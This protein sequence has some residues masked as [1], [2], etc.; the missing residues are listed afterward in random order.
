MLFLGLLASTAVNPVVQDEGLLLG[1]GATQ[2]GRQ[3]LALVAA[4]AFSFT[5]SW[6]L[7]KGVDR[8]LP[9]RVTEDEEQS[10]LDRAMHAET[11]YDFGS[12]RTLGRR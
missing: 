10:G 12:V 11:A 7:A 6:L 5:V 9:W 3:A 2:L 8:V 4:T 1:G